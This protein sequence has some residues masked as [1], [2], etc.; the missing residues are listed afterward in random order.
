MTPYKYRGGSVRVNRGLPIFVAGLSVQQG[1]FE[2]KNG[3]FSASF[4]FPKLA[5]IIKIVLQ[6]GPRGVT[7]G[8]LG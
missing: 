2:K 4:V 7:I 3:S 8:A 6:N 5:L 1:R